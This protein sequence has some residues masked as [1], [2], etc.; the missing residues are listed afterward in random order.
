MTKK[1]EEAKPDI[2][3][4]PDLSGFSDVTPSKGNGWLQAKEGVWVLGKLLG[5]FQMK[6]QDDDK[7][8]GYY[9]IGVR[10]HSDGAIIVAGKGDEAHDVTLERG[11][12]INVDERKALED[13]A[14]F[15]NTD[16]VYEVYMQFGAIQKLG[17]KRTFWPCNIKIKTLRQPTHNVVRTAFNSPP[18]TEENPYSEADY[19]DLPF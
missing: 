8:R 12:T 10:A 17:G 7:P 19:E 11:M 13:L 4:S 6:A 9:Q 14:D 15:A 5:R 18:Q 1:T 16:G 2:P 3:R